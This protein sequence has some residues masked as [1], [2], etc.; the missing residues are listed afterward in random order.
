M[1]EQINGDYDFSPYPWSQLLNGQTWRC[2]PDADFKV[3]PE[4]FAAYVRAAARDRGLAVDV[5][6]ER[7]GSVVLRSR[8]KPAVSV[9]GQ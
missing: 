4:T 9:V 6:V 1:P 2:R 3:K 7:D 8:A 5:K